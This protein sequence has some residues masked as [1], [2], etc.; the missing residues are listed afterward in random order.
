MASLIER[1]NDPRLLDLLRASAVA[2]RRVQHIDLLRL[3]VSVLVAAIGLVS[4]F[5]SSLAG[6]AAVLGG[7]WAALYSLGLAGW[8]NQELRKASV[9]QEMFDVELFDMT[10]NAVVAGDPV[11]PHEVRRL[12][13]QYRGPDELIVDYYEVP[14]VPSP[15]DVVACQQQSLAW[16]A[17]LRRRYAHAVLTGAAA[18]AVVGP[19]VAVVNS[20]TLVAMVTRW[21]VPALGVL[22]LSIDTWRAHRAVAEDRERVLKLLSESVRRSV[23]DREVEA[24]LPQLTREV[25]TLLFLTRVRVPRVPNLFF[26]RH[27]ESDRE[28]F[29]SIMRE[30]EAV[31]RQKPASS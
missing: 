18:L 2:H 17:R 30:L 5:V 11:Q 14:D 7:V 28:D 3:A 29:G 10:W 19:I 16:G 26:L 22:L 9:L 15:Y 27:R 1:Q 31:L 25:Q 24:V 13:K 23:R 6:L 12:S 21:Y 4:A 20:L 8:S